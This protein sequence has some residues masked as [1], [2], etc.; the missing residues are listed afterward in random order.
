MSGGWVTNLKQLPELVISLAVIQVLDVKVA[1][2]KL[3]LLFPL[4][5]QQQNHT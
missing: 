5:L 3:I 2:C 4:V 1:L